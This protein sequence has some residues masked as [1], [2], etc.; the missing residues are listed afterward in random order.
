MK[1][2]LSIS[3]RARVADFRGRGVYSGYPNKHHCIFVHIP[4]A[5]G[6]SVSKSLFGVGS[7][8]VRY[9]EYE[10]ANPKKFEEYFKFCFVRNPWDRLYSAYT[11]LKRGGMNDMDARWARENLGDYSDFPSF[12]RS[13]VTV[14]N[15]WSWVHFKPQHYFICDD[16]LQQKIDFIGKFEVIAHDFDSIVQRIGISP[17]TLPHTNGTDNP[18]SYREHYDEETWQIVASVYGVDIE[19]FGYEDNDYTRGSQV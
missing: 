18:G 10:Q 16:Q 7:R 2:F 14:E 12:V 4:K 19:L 5:A 11:F 17:R 9:T 3:M 15:I 13:W 8:H 6:T 1:D